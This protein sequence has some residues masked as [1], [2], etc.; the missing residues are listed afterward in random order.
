MG[1]DEDG[2]FGRECPDEECLGY[3]KIEPGTGLEGDELPCHC[4]YCG[5]VASHDHFWTQDQLEYAK[6]VAL[7]EAQKYVVGMLQ[8]VFPPARPRKNDFISISFEVKPGA[9]LLLRQYRE[10]ELETVLVCD[11]CGLRYAVYGVFAYC[12]DCGRHNSLQILVSN[13]DLAARE[14]HLADSLD[15]P[16]ADQLVSDALENAVSAFDAFAREL[17]R[18]CG[19]FDIAI[20]SGE[21][22]GSESDRSEGPCRGAVRASIL[23]FPFEANEWG[24]L[25]RAFQKRHLVTHKMG[26][27]DESY[28]ASTGDGTAV[29]GR[30][31][32]LSAAEIESVLPLIR[33]LGEHAQR[34]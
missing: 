21:S 10:K 14:L 4:P 28:I 12:P 7:R 29:K 34:A 22:L 15:Q 33:R 9:P 31:V 1:T 20:T 6:S 23:P 3:F 2:F 16:L 19:D 30:K 11:S 17:F 8:D 32:A 24:D 5:C 25:V 26:V 13:L 27:I 18:E